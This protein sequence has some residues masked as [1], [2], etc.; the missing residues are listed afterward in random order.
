MCT[1]ESEAHVHSLGAYG[2]LLDPWNA[3]KRI[4]WGPVGPLETLPG[5]INALH[6]INMVCSMLVSSAG[7]HVSVVRLCAYS[8]MFNACIS[9]GHVNM[10]GLRPCV[11]PAHG[12]SH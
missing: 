11:S 9:W 2:A 4:V 5:S 10:L 7:D 12:W 3:W 8:H 6:G 1:Y